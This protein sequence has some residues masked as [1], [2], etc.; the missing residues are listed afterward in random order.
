MTACPPTLNVTTLLLVLAGETVLEPLHPTTRV[1][2][3]LLARVER[4]AHR[5]NFQVY[6]L[7]RRRACL[8]RIATRALYERPCVFGMYIC[9][10]KESPY[11]CYPALL[12]YS[13]T[14]VKGERKS[15]RLFRFI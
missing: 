13:I 15:G 12:T 8:E 2:D 5:T 9:L 3:A 1:Y 10:H 7:A 6:M 4:V 11:L 14:P